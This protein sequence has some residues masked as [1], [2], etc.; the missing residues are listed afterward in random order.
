MALSLLRKPAITP[1]EDYGFFGPESVT[2]KVWSYPTSLT[3][4]FQRAVVIE[5]LDPALIAAVDKTQGIYARPRTRYDRTLKYFAMV[6]FADSRSTSQVA[7]ILVKVHSKAVGTDPVTGKRYDANDPDSQLWIHLTAWHS[8]LKAYEMYGPG[9]LS[10]A[11]ERQYWAECAVAAELQTCSPA[12]CPRDR[13]ELRAYYDRMRPQLLGSDIARKAMQHLLDASVM[14]PPLPKV[15]APLTWL[16]GRTLRA[17]TIATMPHWMREMGGLRQ[18]RA[19]DLAVVPVLRVAFVLANLNK[20]VKLELLGFLSPMTKPVVAPILYGVE[21]ANPIVRTPTEARTLY[22]Y[23][24]P[25]DAHLDLRARQADR[26]FG[27]GRAPSDEGIIESE[28][29][30]GSTGM[31]S[32]SA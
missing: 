6:A 19:V 25:A 7:D 20:R 9:K 29:I 28:P 22:G 10:A 27:E 14:L 5:E 32:A 21:P 13:D 31:S 15:L 23:D 26:V 8:I 12:D 4:G 3:V 24:R 18:S 30:L 11:E 17:A 1:N 16:V 2:W